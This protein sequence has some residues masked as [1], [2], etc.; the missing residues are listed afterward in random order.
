MYV[1]SPEGAWG[2]ELADLLLKR[3]VVLVVSVGW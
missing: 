2:S 1:H 3:L